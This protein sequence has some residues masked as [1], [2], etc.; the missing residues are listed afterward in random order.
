[1]PPA[2]VIVNPK[3]AD[4]DYPI[5]ELAGVGVAFKFLQAMLKGSDRE[6]LLDQS[7]DLVALGTVAD[8]IHLVSENRYWVKRGIEILNATHRIGIQE[9][10][11]CANVAQGT[12]DSR[13]ISWTLG[14][15][16]NAAGRIDN[17]TTSYKLL[18][19]N[20][21]EEARSLAAQLEKKNAERLEITN[22]L[23]LKAREKIIADGVDRPLLMA[24]DP[25][26]PQGVMGLVAGRL[27]DQFYRPVILFKQGS[28]GCRGSAR[29]I[30]EFDMMAALE[31]NHD[32]LSKY[33][34]HKM[35]AG[36]NIPTKNVA[37]FRER[38]M[39]LA[40]EQ[41]AGLDLRPHIDIDAEVP[42]SI[43]TGT[44]YS[45][46]QQLAPFGM[47]NPVPI[48]ISRRVRVDQQRLVGSQGEH[49]KLKLKENGV[50]WDAIGFNCGSLVK[51]V[52][53]ELDIVYTLG[54]DRWNGTDNLRVNLLDF[55]PVR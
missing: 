39:A 23:M 15:R 7:L 34:G 8:M 24:S 14:P 35:A 43:F 25:D 41:L 49:L 16:I 52:T 45:Q 31:L 3:R 30:A 1:L 11:R 26:Y 42:L 4:S 47:G 37:A 19:T 48:F 33:G 51:E 20:D 2:H 53:P 27:A 18:M 54:I 6:D 44:M 22:N 21:P 13:T 50:L 5:T 12:I 10:M 36:F 55:A 17:A 29:S 46:I 32:L 28:E 38:I 9:M 40:R